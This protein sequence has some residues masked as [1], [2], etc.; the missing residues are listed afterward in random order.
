MSRCPRTPRPCRQVPPVPKPAGRHV[1]V[2]EGCRPSQSRSCKSPWGSL[3][4]SARATAGKQ[5]S[6]PE[7]RL[8][9]ARGWHKRERSRRYSV[10]RPLQAAICR[11]EELAIDLLA[12]GLSVRDIEDAFEDESQLLRFANASAVAAFLSNGLIGMVSRRSPCTPSRH[13]PTHPILDSAVAG[14]SHMAR[15][16]GFDGNPYDSANCGP[17]D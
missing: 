17:R 15:F 3:D 12:R 5:E 16:S 14:R 10:I 13:E 7:P 4:V 1:D 9:G 8:A 6:G 2:D 11:R